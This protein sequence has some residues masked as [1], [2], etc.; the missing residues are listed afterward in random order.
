MKPLKAEALVGWVKHQRNPA[1]VF[2]V[3][4]FT[5]FHP[6]YSYLPNS[7]MTWMPDDPPIIK[8]IRYFEDFAAQ[9]HPEVER[10]WIRRVLEQPIMKIRYYADTDTL[11]IELTNKPVA[12]TDAVSDDLILDYDTEGKVVAITLDNYSKNV[13]TVDLQT[14]GVSLLAA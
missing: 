6:T 7:G 4:G 5:A 3:L 8:T 2:L 14:F 1:K 11:A 10:I 9:K 13:D 12:A